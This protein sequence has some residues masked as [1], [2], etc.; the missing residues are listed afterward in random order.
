MNSI[1]LGIL[2]LLLVAVAG[3]MWIRAFRA[4]RVPENRSGYVG[5][6]IAGAAIGIAALAGSP[7]W[8]GGVPAALAVAGASFFLLMV[9]I[10]R[11]RVGES[12]LAVGAA[13][14]PFS[15]LDENRERF[16]SSSLAGKPALIKFFRGHW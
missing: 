16:D 7:G 1:A 14:P 15:A 9:A 11:Q 6:W 10:S 13:F 2:A 4:V 12:V 5:F 3:G 8:G